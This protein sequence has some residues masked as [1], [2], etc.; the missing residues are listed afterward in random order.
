MQS[1]LRQLWLALFTLTPIAFAALCFVA[2]SLEW[3]FPGEAASQLGRRIDHLYHVIAWIVGAV[4][5]GTN[6]VLVWSLAK[7]S[8]EH[9][10]RGRYFHGNHRVEIAWTAI[11]FLILC[12]IAVY[13]GQVWADM[14]VQSSFPSAVT[15]GDKSLTAI[16]EVQAR[17]YEWR[18]RYPGLN[19]A[20]EPLE[21]TSEEKGSD[22]WTVNELHVPAGRP[23]L[24]KLKT[25]DVQHSFYLPEFRIKQDAVPGLRIPVW[26]EADKP[27]EYV[28]QCAELCGWGHYKMNAKVV[29][30]EPSEY[31]AWRRAAEKAE[32]DDG[33]KETE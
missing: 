20:G 9:T 8:S 31:D 5:V 10:T 28:L 17:Q 33:F 7:G 1:L 25:Q 2:P 6:V 4:F 3:S 32:Q 14:K 13:Q 30:H 29:A 21:L 22:V 23:V 26:F 15:D 12:F 27:G 19:D 11:P 24:I 16:A 18:I